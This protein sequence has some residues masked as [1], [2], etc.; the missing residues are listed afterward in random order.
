MFVIAPNIWELFICKSVVKPYIVHY[1]HVN[2]RNWKENLTSIFAF[3]LTYG[4]PLTCGI[5]SQKL[6]PVTPLITSARSI[7]LS[8]WF[9]SV[10]RWVLLQRHYG[11]GSRMAM[12]YSV[13]DCLFPLFSPLALD[14]ILV[15]TS[16]AGEGGLPHRFGFVRPAL[17]SGV[18]LTV[19]MS[20]SNRS[21][22][23]EVC[24]EFSP[25]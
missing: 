5:I 20:Q 14:C 1:S 6:H 19:L 18:A 24:F 23:L 17:Y 9:H 11:I 15:A 4:P 13:Q 2:N 25:R 22:S 16:S 12:A 10:G 3:P 7:I 8:R 21:E